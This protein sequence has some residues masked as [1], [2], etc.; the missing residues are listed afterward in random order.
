ME[1]VVCIYIRIR[2]LTDTKLPADISSPSFLKVKQSGSRSALSWLICV[3]DTKGLWACNGDN[4]P[5]ILLMISIYEVNESWK[6]T[7]KAW[8]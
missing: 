5:M 6:Q 8:L 3:M 7:E 2:Q 4:Q 1:V